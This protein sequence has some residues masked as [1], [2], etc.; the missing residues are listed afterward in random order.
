MLTNLLTSHTPSLSHYICPYHPHPCKEWTFTNTLRLPVK[1]AYNKPVTVS[2]AIWLDINCCKVLPAMPLF[3]LTSRWQVCPWLGH[4][5]VASWCRSLPSRRPG[6]WPAP[7]LCPDRCRGWWW[8]PEAEGCPPGWTA[9]RARSQGCWRSGCTQ[10]TSSGCQR[11]GDLSREKHHQHCVSCYICHACWE[12]SAP[13]ICWFLHLS[14]KR[15]MQIWGDFLNCQKVDAL[16]GNVNHYIKADKWS[17][18]KQTSQCSLHDTVAWPMQYDSRYGSCEMSW[19]VGEGGR[20]IT[21]KF[22][23]KNMA[24]RH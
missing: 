23:W 8:C 21:K 10:W 12:L 19:G 13:F 2:S 20:G 11:S 22:S 7:C 6:R 17:P 4:V 24:D 14:P 15:S 1:H 9:G 18:Q 16:M 5:A 3:R